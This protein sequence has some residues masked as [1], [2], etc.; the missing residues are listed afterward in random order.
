MENKL[1][2]IIIGQHFGPEAVKIVSYLLSQPRKTAYDISLVTGLKIKIVQLK[3]ICLIKHNII[4]AEIVEIPPPQLSGSSHRFPHS[5]SV[6]TVD[7]IVILTRLRFP[8]YSQYIRD[9]FGENLV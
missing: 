3:L 2:N 5:I 4:F 1:V 6:F 7:K 8:K 9:N